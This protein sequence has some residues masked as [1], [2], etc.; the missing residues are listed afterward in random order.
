[1]KHNGLVDTTPLHKCNMN[2]SGSC[3]SMESKLALSMVTD[4]CRDTNGA[5]NIGQLVT[6]DLKHNTQRNEDKIK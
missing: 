4:I 5:A 6:D 1:M 2:H 3:G